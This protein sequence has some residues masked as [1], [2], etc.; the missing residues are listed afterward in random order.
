VDR[1]GLDMVVVEAGDGNAIGR[2]VAIAAEQRANA[3]V[4]GNDA[5]LISRSEQV[6]LSAL[7][8]SL[9]TICEARE[10]VAAG[11]F[12][13]YGPN[14]AETFRHAGLYVARILKGEKAADLPVIQPTTYDLT[15]NLRTARALGVS[16]PPTLL[17]RADEVIE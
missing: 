4:V 14:Q 12:L 13:S 15:V 3:L 8:H 9:P 11:L 1:L 5:Y 7:H 17:A 16:I 2:A 10:G 6:A